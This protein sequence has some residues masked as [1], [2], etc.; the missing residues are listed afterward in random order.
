MV[1]MSN[2]EQLRAGLLPAITQTVLEFLLE[3]TLVDFPP[4][5]TSRNAQLLNI[6]ACRMS[7]MSV[8]VKTTPAHSAD[9]AEKVASA[10]AAP[11]PI[12]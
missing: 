8:D 11:N 10:N 3:V 4:G 1:S 2:C 9:A 7:T 5:A 6:C 12:G